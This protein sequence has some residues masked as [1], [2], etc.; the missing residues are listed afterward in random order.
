MDTQLADEL[1]QLASTVERQIPPTLDGLMVGQD[2]DSQAVMECGWIVYRLG[3]ALSYLSTQQDPRPLRA[4]L[5]LL[6]LVSPA[7]RAWLRQ[8]DPQIRR[9]WQQATKEQVLASMKVQGGKV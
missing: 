9:L 1:L 5:W 2:P 4:M 3:A 6:E 8:N 7:A